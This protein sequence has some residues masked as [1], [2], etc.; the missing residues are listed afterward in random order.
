[1]NLLE[2]YES[3]CTFK[4]EILS[5]LG[6]NEPGILKVAI[7]LRKLYPCEHELM[8][9]K[10]RFC[11]FRNDKGNFEI[12]CL[13]G[14]M[15]TY[16]TECIIPTKR[17]KDKDISLLLLLG[18]PASHS[19]S[20]RMFFSYERERQSD[21][22]GKDHRFWKALEETCVLRFTRKCSY[23]ENITERSESRKREL[24]D[25]SYLSDF[26]IGLS[27]FYSMPSSASGSKWAGVD[28]LRRLFGNATLQKIVEDEKRRIKHIID[29]FLGSKGGI[30]A[31]HKNSY[32]QADCLLHKSDGI[33]IW[34]A[35][36]TRLIRGAQNIEQL[37]KFKECLLNQGDN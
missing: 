23:S 7:D 33:R 32:E 31:F 21:G 28:G 36:P 8:E 26:R 24:Y 6:I 16:L 15:L 13:K 19:V 2:K 30:F 5:F 29:N 14:D 34:R 10:R 18:N 12:M 9:F 11:E 17:K 3:P 27:T 25:L 4:G 37:R 1:M 35:P 20:S 22:T